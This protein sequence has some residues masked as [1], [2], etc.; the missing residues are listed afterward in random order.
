M[1]VEL[2]CGDTITIPEGCKAIVKDGSVVFEKEEKEKVQEFKDGDILVSTANG[3][4]HNAFIYKVEDKKGSHS[5]YIGIDICGQLSFDK[6]LSCRWGNY[7][8]SYA[9]EEEKQALFD[10]ME[11]QGLRWNAEEKKV[12]NIRWRAKEGG[13]YYFTDVDLIVKSLDDTYSTFDNKL[14][15]AL[16]YFHTEEQAEEAARRVKET[17]QKYHEEI[18][19]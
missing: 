11:Q 2:Q 14:W 17:L 13:D 6:Y 1:K 10:K 3:I 12:E 9:T 18:G 19:E 7:D 8:L 5:Y 15:N 16:N 4:R